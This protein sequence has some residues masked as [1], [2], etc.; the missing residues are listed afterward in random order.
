M[1]LLIKAIEEGLEPV[2]PSKPPKGGVGAM[3][4]RLS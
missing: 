1:A 2:N 3:P 4:R